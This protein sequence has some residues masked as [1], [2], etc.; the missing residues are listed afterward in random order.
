[1]KRSWFVFLLFFIILSVWSSQGL[2]QNKWQFGVFL[3][4]KM[5]YRIMWSNSG[6]EKGQMLVEEQNKRDKARF[7]LDVGVAVY[8]NVNENMRLKTG[9]EFTHSGYYHAFFYSGELD[10]LL[11][12]SY[13]QSTFSESQT[14][15][16]QSKMETGH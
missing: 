11:N 2:A 15:V 16:K 1:M 3:T 10:S 7:G 12:N 13:Y 9:L 14:L 6:D 8:Y 4:P 5:D